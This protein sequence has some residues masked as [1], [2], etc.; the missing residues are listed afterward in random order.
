[1]GSTNAMTID[2][3]KTQD[4]LSIPVNPIFDVMTYPRLGGLKFT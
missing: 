4:Y 3:K 2:K 1:M